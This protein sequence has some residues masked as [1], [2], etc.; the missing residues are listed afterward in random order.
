MLTEKRA[1]PIV[2]SQLV[3]LAIRYL[4][5]RGVDMTRHLGG[6]TITESGVSLQ[7]GA[8]HAFFDACEKASGEDWLGIE[9][10]TVRPV[11]SHGIVEFFWRSAA[12]LREGLQIL[13]THSRLLNEVGEMRL[14]EGRD[15]SFIQSVDADPLGMG[16]HGNEFFVA[17][18]VREIRALIS[19]EFSPIRARFAHARP[20][21]DLGLL[22]RALGT[23][24]VVWND[25]ASGIDFD[26]GWLE[27]RLV[28]ADASL[29]TTLRAH[30]DAWLPWV[31]QD[32]GEALD[33]KLSAFLHASI[34]RPVAV[35]A[36][37]RQLGVSVRTLQR[38]LSERGTTFHVLADA[39]LAAHACRVVEAGGVSVNE[40]ARRLGYG[41]PAAFVRAFRRWTGSTPTAWRDRR[42]DRRER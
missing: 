33:S 3:P 41:S 19:P 39:V 5:E 15:A 9:L 27:A 7:L 36:A 34:G 31:S 30:T 11:G 29:A 10:A 20:A 17:T 23:K 32:A 24:D 40:I 8:L 28:T 6:A 21:G 25:A 37:A 22:H 13:A 12:T 4:S 2:R 1:T 38:R 35:E 26:P 14:A 18:L 42:R 16:R